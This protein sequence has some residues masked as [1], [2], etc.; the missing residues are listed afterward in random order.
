MN[1][2]IANEVMDFGNLPFPEHLSFGNEEELV[3]MVMEG[4]RDVRERKVV[5]GETVFQEIRDRYGFSV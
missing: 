3:E 2:R 5:P 1:E 4:L